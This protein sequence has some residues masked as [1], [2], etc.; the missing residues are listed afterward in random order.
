METAPKCKNHLLF[1]CGKNDD[2]EEIRKIAMD[3]ILSGCREFHFFGRQEPLWHMIFDEVDMEIN[4]NS[5]EGNV[6][7]TTRYSALEKFQ[8]ELVEGAFRI[9]R[10]GG[11][12]YV[13]RR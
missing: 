13:R 11:N 9:Y 3:L 12:N 6:V 10:I 8:E 7:L 1:P 4:P 2:K 5:T